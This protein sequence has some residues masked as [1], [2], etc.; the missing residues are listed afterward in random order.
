MDECYWYGW[1]IDYWMEGGLMRDMFTHKITTPE[2]W[3]MLMM[4]TAYTK[5]ELDYD[6]VV[7]AD[8]VVTPS[9]DPHCTNDDVSGGCEPV[10]VIS[11][12]KLRDHSEG[13]AETTKIA[14]VLMNDA[15][16][17][18]YVI[19]PEAWDCIWEELIQNGK[20]LKTVFDRP[21]T[22]ESD[23]SFSAEMLQRMISELD[24]IIEKYGG[25][26]WNTKETANRVVDLLVEHRTLIQKELNEVNTGVRKLSEQ[27]FLG[28]KERERRRKLKLKEEGA[29]DDTEP[30]T[31]HSGYFR[32]IEERMQESKRRKM[33]HLAMK[34]LKEE[35]RQGAKKVDR[36][37]P[38]NSK[39]SE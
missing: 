19:A 36:D 29:R 17:G 30:P 35:E 33:R 23:Y 27:D 2:H 25:P 5:A 7:G 11:A 10:A 3:N 22:S 18:Q 13:P 1:F 34:T 39:I 21:A 24:R 15:R 32:A 12:E 16:T 28:P 9:Y 26:E 8:T 4:P 20:G 14:N 38:S 6:L 31:D 37:V